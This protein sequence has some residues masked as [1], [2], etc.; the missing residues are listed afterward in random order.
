MNHVCFR[1]SKSST[2]K[3][4]SAQTCAPLSNLIQ[5]VSGVR[6][7]DAVKLRSCGG[8][9]FQLK[10]ESLESLESEFK[11]NLSK[12]RSF[13]PGTFDVA[14][15]EV[16]ELLVEH[17]KTKEIL[18]LTVEAV[19]VASHGVGVELVDRSEIGRK[20]LEEFVYSS[21]SPESLGH[22][23]LIPPQKIEED[24]VV[25]Q[26]DDSHDT[27]P[28]EFASTEAQVRVSPA[29]APPKNLQLRIRQ[30][31]VPQRQIMARTGTLPERVAL[32]RT[33]GASVWEALLSNGQLTGTEVAKIARNGQ[34]P[35]PML[36]QI[37][38]NQAWLA[39]SEVRRALLTSPR[40]S[41]PSLDSVLRAMPGAELKLVPKQTAY[42]AKV[43]A[44][45][46][47]L[48]PR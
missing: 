41:G 30:L 15:R 39:K 48:L 1:E 2:E 14:E 28:A 31:A 36:T 9:Q 26:S 21:D 37:V 12:F 19:Y 47:R 27:E 17:P 43:R 6:V 32:E 4:G 20:V 40:L 29:V 10:F 35:I 46:T 45:A 7:C 25:E 13:V 24:K 23:S 33:F 8:V 38:A 16:C 42:P 22:I 11:V 44:A 5:Y 3:P 18:P 34:A